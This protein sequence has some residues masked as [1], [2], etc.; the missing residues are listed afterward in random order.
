MN[1]AQQFWN[2][3][4]EWSQKTFGLDSERGPA[5]P[6]DHLEKEAKEAYYE[7][8]SGDYLDEPEKLDTEIA[9]CLFLVF[10]AARRSGM[11]LDGLLDTA[12]R[13]LEVNKQRKWQTPTP[14]V[15]LAIEHV[16][17]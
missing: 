10:D 1:R 11:T 15:E 5:G 3:Q 4:G 7:V 9:D 14:G 6:L 12:F 2:E 17:D 16:R 13:K 8:V